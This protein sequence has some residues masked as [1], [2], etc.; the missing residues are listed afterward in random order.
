MDGQQA[1][2][3]QGLIDS[4]DFTSEIYDLCNRTSACICPSKGSGARSGRLINVT[5]AAHG[6]SKLLYIYSDY[7]AKVSLYISKLQKHLAPR[8]WFPQDSCQEFLRAH[9]GQRLVLPRGGSHKDWRRVPNDHYGDCTKLHLIARALSTRCLET[10]SAGQ[11]RRTF[12][13]K[14]QISHTPI[15]APSSA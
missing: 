2:V 8:I 6:L 1:A 9:M 3:N 4:G 5:E 7:H 12:Y 11:N 15:K 10:I 13:D 14:P